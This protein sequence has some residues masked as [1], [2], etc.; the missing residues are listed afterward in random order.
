MKK[1]EF[2]DCQKNGVKDIVEIKVGIDGLTIAQSKAGGSTKL[3]RKQVFQALAAQVPDKDGKLV[4]NPYKKWSEIDPSLPDVKIEVLGPP[5]TSGTRDSFHELFL[6]HGALE[7]PSLKDLTTADSKAF[8]AVWKSI[9][10][11]GAYVEAGENDNVIVQKLEA[12]KDA[13]GIFGYSFLEENTAKLKGVA[14]EGVEPEYDVI[15]SGK[16]KGAR[17]LFI[18]VKKQHVGVVPGIDKFVEEYVSEK[19]MSKDGYLARKGLVALP[20][21]EADKVRETALGMKTL[22]ADLVN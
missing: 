11:D 19:A 6:E 12:N 3:T 18:Y 21:E 7:F 2:E 9:R 17:P 14:I 13:Y 22:S 8:D 1:G 4:A 5:P 10:K 20:K 16:Y 15:S